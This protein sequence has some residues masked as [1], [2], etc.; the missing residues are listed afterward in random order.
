MTVNNHPSKK[1]LGLGCSFTNPEYVYQS[2]GYDLGPWPMW[3]ELIGKHYNKPV[4]NLGEN[5]AGNPYMLEQLLDHFDDPDID[6]VCMLATEWP[7]RHITLTKDK[8]VKVNTTWARRDTAHK[9]KPLT[10]EYFNYTDY[11]GNQPSEHNFMFTAEDE[12]RNFFNIIHTM[13]R[14]CHSHN[15]RFLVL[16]GL[17]ALP[18]TK[19]AAHDAHQ[20]ILRVS[21][22]YESKIDTTDLIDWPFTSPSWLERHNYNKELVL[23]MTHHPTPEGQQDIANRFIERIGDL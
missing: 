1:I 3:P 23:S 13:Q 9:L 5:G 20:T 16:K 4:L 14:L 8:W 17:V 15:K 2:R 10:A 11:K 19:I 22:E 12:T 21:K 6:I 7:R 18:F